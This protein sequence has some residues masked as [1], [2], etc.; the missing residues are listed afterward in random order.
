MTLELRSCTYSYRPW[1]AP[2]LDNL[3]YTLPDGLTI[4]L[5]PNGAGKSTLLKLA[6]SVHLPRR[7]TVTL[8]GLASRSRDYRRAVAWMPQHITAMSHLTAREQV[9]YTGWL[10]G[11][12]RRDAWDRAA[13]ALARVD[14]A[15]RADTKAGRLSGGQLRRVGVASALVHGARVMLL[16]EPTAGMDP[17]QRRVFR[18]VLGSLT[19]DVR[20]L[21]STHD[22]AD[23]AEESDSVTVIDDGRVI[24]TGT[25]SAFLA[26]APAGTPS[27]RT[28]E[29]A[30]TALSESGRDL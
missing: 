3:D 17:R 5:G 28:A 9:A 10:K 8:D 13:T 22:V 20:V 1:A 15:A 14:L 6:A 26:H 25:T 23:L 11:M 30:Y 4:L 21:L 18:D 16:D 29:A 12:S 27:G 7:G 2:V 19:E 24:H